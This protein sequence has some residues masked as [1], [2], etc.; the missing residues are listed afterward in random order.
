MCMVPIRHAWMTHSAMP[1]SLLKIFEGASHCP[2]ND[3][4]RHFTDVVQ[5]FL[6][7]TEPAE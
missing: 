7:A 4:P 1:S 2:F 5:R 3:N 6:D